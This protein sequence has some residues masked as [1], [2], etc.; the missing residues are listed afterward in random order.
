M[1]AFVVTISANVRIE[2]EDDPDVDVQRGAA[3]LVGRV[4]ASRIENTLLPNPGGIKVLS[5]EVGWPEV[6]VDGGA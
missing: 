4:L 2:I 1:R 6:I 3:T 5:T